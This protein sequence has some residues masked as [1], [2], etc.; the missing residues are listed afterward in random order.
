MSK[1]RWKSTYVP[2]YRRRSVW[3][4]AG[5]FLLCVWAYA[6]ISGLLAEQRLELRIDRY[7][8]AGEPVCAEQVARF[9]DSGVGN[10]AC[11]RRFGEAL[12]ARGK[13]LSGETFIHESR[14]IPFLDRTWSLRSDWPE[15]S[16]HKAEAYIATHAEWLA[17]LSELARA[18]KCIFVNYQA[19][20]RYADIRL[21]HVNSIAHGVA[22]LCVKA[23]VL[24]H[25][26]QT[27]EAVAALWEAKLVNR[28]LLHEP[29]LFNAV[30][31]LAGERS[32]LK[33]VKHLLTTDPLSQTQ[34]EQLRRICVPFGKRRLQQ[35]IL[36]ERLAGLDYYY[37]R[38]D[39]DVTDDVGHS[40]SYLRLMPLSR[41]CG[42]VEQYLDFVDCCAVVFE[43]PV[44]RR[45]PVAE[46]LMRCQCECLRAGNPFLSLAPPICLLTKNYLA[47]CNDAR[48]ILK[49][50]CEHQEPDALGNAQATLDPVTR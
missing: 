41:A 36:V 32:I 20:E 40:F 3:A 47:Y 49:T 18:D 2:F 46:E 14:G 5:L 27:E 29:F 50:V 11:S 16:F 25:H 37:Q 21:H 15:N 12:A 9:L 33:V 17:T 34:K 7:V 19:I 10:G 30:T 13:Y 43:L 42:K 4:A 31:A 35:S 38:A 45:V 48:E 24:V 39:P 8:C 28:H 22:C 44:H 23:A 1:S 6:R 26:A